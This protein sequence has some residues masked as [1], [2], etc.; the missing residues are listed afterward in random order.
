[1]AVVG[2][3]SSEYKLKGKTEK[4]KELHLLKICLIALGNSYVCSSSVWKRLAFEA[5]KPSF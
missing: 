2:L 1:M 4:E 5:D 3:C